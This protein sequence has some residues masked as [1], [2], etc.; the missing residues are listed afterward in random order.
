MFEW[1]SRAWSQM[2]ALGKCDVHYASLQ[3]ERRIVCAVV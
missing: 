2:M 1:I 3:P